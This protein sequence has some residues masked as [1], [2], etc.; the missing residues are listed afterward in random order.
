LITMLNGARVLVTRPA[1]QAE[2]LSRLITERGGSAIR[3]P[4]LAIAAMDDPYPIKNTLAHLDRFQWLVFI[5]ANAVSMHSYYID[6][7][8]INCFKSTRI[9]A[10]GQAT[11]EALALAGLPVDL[12]PES[13][14]NSEALLAMP[15][16]Q[17]INGQNCLI[18]RGAGGREE[19]ATTLRSRGANVEYL[20]VYKRIIPG[21]DS[22][23]I[24]LLLAQDKLD[25]ITITSGEA[26]QNL[27][28]MLSK[29]YHQRLLAVPLVVISDRIRQIAARMGFERIAVSNSPS[30][31]AILETVIKCVSGEIEWPN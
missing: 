2:N 23:Q 31:N 6:G 17:Q 14:F 26:L 29:E 5:S 12:V 22:S 19:L 27:L 21:I 1:H 8:K 7:G 9:A 13:G 16:M 28:T 18:V 24:F 4:T 25:V 30:D 10:I 11:A 15:Q 3:F 20:D